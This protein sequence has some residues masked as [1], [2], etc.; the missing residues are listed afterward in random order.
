MPNKQWKSQNHFFDK[1]IK[2]YLDKHPELK[3]SPSLFY[4]DT[5]N[6]DFFDVDYYSDRRCQNCR[7]TSQLTDIQMLSNKQKQY[8]TLVNFKGECPDYLPE[9]F[10]FTRSTIESV[11]HHFNDTRPWI[12]KPVGGSFRKGVTVVKTWKDLTDTVNKYKWRDWVLQ[13]F[14]TPP[15]LCDGRKFHFRVYVLVVK[16]YQS[17]DVYIYRKGIMY[18]AK[19]PYQLTQTAPDK[20]H[21]ESLLSGGLSTENSF[22]FPEKFAE[23]FNQNLFDFNIF[24]QMCHIV[25]DTIMSVQNEIMCPN[26]KNRRDYRCFKLLGYDILCDSNFQLYLGEINARRITFKYPPP[27][28]KKQ[29]YFNLLDIV[30]RDRFDSDK[31]YFYH[32]QNYHIEETFTN[33]KKSSSILDSLRPSNTQQWIGLILLS[34][35]LLALLYE[36]IVYVLEKKA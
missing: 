36:I 10:S 6:L 5:K 8:K 21:S 25:Q 15:A 19:Q 12:I 23:C 17:L 1:I 30:L 9:T 13:R 26:Q 35:I 34:F 2:E 33:P 3:L 31:N 32:L 14:I 20:D 27:W 29:L 24:P 4:R 18:F 7:V 11:R 16:S 22:V 28:L